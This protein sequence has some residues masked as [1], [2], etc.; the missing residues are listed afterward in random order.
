ME[1]IQPS[2]TPRVGFHEERAKKRK[3]RSTTEAKFVRAKGWQEFILRACQLIKPCR[4]LRERAL[5]D[6]PTIH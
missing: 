5:E 6:D 1:N 3:P 2:L 4:L